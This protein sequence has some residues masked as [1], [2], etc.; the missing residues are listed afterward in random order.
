MD[1]ITNDK[2]IRDVFRHKQVTFLLEGLY[3]PLGLL[4]N[5]VYHY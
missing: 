5:R 1:Q 4:I 3:Y 2:V